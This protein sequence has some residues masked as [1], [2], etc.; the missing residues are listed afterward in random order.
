MPLS[1]KEVIKILQK[2]GFVVVRQKGSHIVLHRQT[3]Q[4]KKIGVVPNH[5]EVQ[6]GTLRSIAKMTEVNRKKLGV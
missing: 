5:T 3:S 1:A 6:K 4:G 2:E